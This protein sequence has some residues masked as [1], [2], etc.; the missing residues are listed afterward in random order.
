MLDESD[1]TRVRTIRNAYKIT[2]EEQARLRAKKVG[3]IGL[4]VGRLY[5]SA[6]P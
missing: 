6:S 3:I 5:R 4:S 1:F 2:F